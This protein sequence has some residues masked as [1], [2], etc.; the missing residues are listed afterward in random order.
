VDFSQ[1]RDEISRLIDG[2]NESLSRLDP[3]TDVALLMDSPEFTTLC[4]I[5]IL[6]TGAEKWAGQFLLE[7][8]WTLTDRGGK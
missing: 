5:H 4:R 6:L 2:V 7:T 3:D 8:R 1:L